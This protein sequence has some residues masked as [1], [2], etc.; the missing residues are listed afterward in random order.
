[1]NDATSVDTAQPL[2][3]CSGS[4][5]AGADHEYQPSFMVMLR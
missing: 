5:S 2:R 1:M 4:A 3:A